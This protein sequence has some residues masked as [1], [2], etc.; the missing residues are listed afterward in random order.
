MITPGE[1]DCAKS[2]LAP[3][4]GRYNMVACG[5][6]R[7]IVRSTSGHAPVHTGQTVQEIADDGTPTLTRL[8]YG[9]S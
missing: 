7:D 4:F 3:S 5:C 2:R 1:K 9:V 6:T 8:M